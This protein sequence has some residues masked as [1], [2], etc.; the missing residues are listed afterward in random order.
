LHDVVGAVRRANSFEATGS[1]GQSE[2]LQDELVAEYLDLTQAMAT[3]PQRTR[4]VG[5][6][7]LEGWRVPEIA[8]LCGVSV[9]TVCRE[10]RN[11]REWLLCPAAGDAA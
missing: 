7:M 6:L 8:A 9:R 4:Q 1:F 3:I 10:R 5:R 11:F 2:R